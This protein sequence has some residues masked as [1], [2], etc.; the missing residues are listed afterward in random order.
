MSTLDPSLAR[1][2]QP[3]LD[4]CLL[5]AARNGR[6]YSSMAKGSIGRSQTRARRTEAGETMAKRFSP[7]SWA[8]LF[9]A[10]V[11]LSSFK[12]EGA[13]SKSLKILPRLIE[14]LEKLQ[15]K[16]HKRN[17]LSKLSCDACKA[18]VGIL[19]RLYS[20]HEDK[21]VSAVTTFCIDYKIED[22]NVC[23]LVV[24]EFKVSSR[25]GCVWPLYCH[26]D[27][28]VKNQA[29]SKLQAACLDA[30]SSGDIVT[31]PLGAGGIS[32]DRTT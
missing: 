5:G 29:S 6:G 14:G 23:K 18:G 13:P 11:I 10:L 3:A 7:A 15:Q 19:D 27:I 31:S 24:Q 21:F 2:G 4:R 26:V 16:L 17:L 12:T 30:S 8:V 28:C 25:R 32:H 20:Q 9:A 1:E 22:R